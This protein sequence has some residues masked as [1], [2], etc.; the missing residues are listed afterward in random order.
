M[1]IA[2]VPNHCVAAAV[3]A[4]GAATVAVQM[5][6][7]TP[8]PKRC[9]VGTVIGSAGLAAATAHHG[10]TGGIP[11]VA[12]LLGG[13]AGLAGVGYGL[14]SHTDPAR[15]PMSCKIGTV[16][17]I[18][19]SAT[20]TPHTPPHTPCA[21]WRRV[22]THDD[23]SEA[24]RGD[25]FSCLMATRHLSGCRQPAARAR[26]NPTFILPRP[27]GHP[28]V[29]CPC[30]LQARSW[31]G[32]AGKEVRRVA[33]PHTPAK[34]LRG[35]GAQSIPAHLS[36]SGA[37]Q[38][39]SSGVGQLSSSRTQEASK[40]YTVLFVLYQRDETVERSGADQPSNGGVG[41]LSIHI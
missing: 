9:M 33:R 10:S 11:H 21:R 14:S 32:D 30:A 36:A 4:A 6:G 7:E 25:P 27:R 34:E 18:V 29:R 39:S 37:D 1:S 5:H 26:R 3:V 8:V 24:V 17:G 19:M 13:L 35:E 20:H 28:P 38:P 2:G 40:R 16:A 31:H 41:Q 12:C 15:I 22:M 23:E